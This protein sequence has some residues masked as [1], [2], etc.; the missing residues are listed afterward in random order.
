M[1]RK[2]KIDEVTEDCHFSSYAAE[3]VTAETG[4]ASIMTS[5]GNG[6][7]GEELGPKQPHDSLPVMEYLQRQYPLTFL[8]YFDYKNPE[9]YMPD[10]AQNA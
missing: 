8:P 9:G 5:G 1:S 10:W 2:P 4:F 7:I 3:S 6:D